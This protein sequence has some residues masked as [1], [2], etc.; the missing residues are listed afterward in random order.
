VSDASEVHDVADTGQQRTPIMRFREVGQAR[1][2]YTCAGWQLRDVAAG[3]ANLPAFGEQAQGENAANEAGGSCD[4]NARL[5]YLV[6]PL[7]RYT[8]HC[9]TV[10]RASRE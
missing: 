9:C 10:G 1:R 6:G 7:E 3:G 8:L 2:F 4:Q 5:H